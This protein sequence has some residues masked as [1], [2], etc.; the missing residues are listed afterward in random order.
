MSVSSRN[1]GAT[2]LTTCPNDFAACASPFGPN[3]T[4]A[5]TPTRTNSGA[6]TPRK[7]RG[8]TVEDLRKS[9]PVPFS[10]PGFLFV[11]IGDISETKGREGRGATPR[12][13]AVVV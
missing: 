11:R 7:A 4:R 6:P 5:T 12:V 13:F 2:D 9:L 1:V 8:T 10:S 3:R